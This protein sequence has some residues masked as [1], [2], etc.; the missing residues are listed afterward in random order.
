[1]HYDFDE[2][3][4]RLGTYCTQWDY[5]EDRFNKKDLIPFSISDTDF[6]IPKPITK[7]IH[8][9]ADHQIYGYTRWNHHDFKSSITTYFKRRFDTDMEE[10]RILYSPSVM[11]SVSLLIRLLSQPHDKVLTMNPMYD[12]F[13]NVIK[14]NDR[15]LLSH[16]LI[17]EEGTFKIDFDVFEKQAQES[18]LLLLC[19]PHNPTGRIWSDEEMH[20]M[21]QICKKYQV[22]IISDEIHM[23]IRIKDAKHHPLMKY[24]D[25]YKEI[26]TASSSSKTLNTPGLIGSYVIIPDEKIRDE[27]LGVTRRRDFLNSASIFGMYA[28]MIG[29]TECDDYINQLN[30]YIRGNM[31][32]VENFIRDELKDFKFQRPEATYLAWI[33]ARDVP[34]TS[35]EIQ[36]ALVNVGG[37]AIMK[38]EIYG[39]NGAKYLRMNLGCPRSKIEEGL[40]RFKK[41]MDYLYNK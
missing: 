16:Y 30:E 40:K 32:L 39:E 17:K 38:G 34:F 28:T 14:E 6:I 8:E 27:F 15:E 35:D 10:D 20:R 18:A 23:D 37:V 3:H 24:Y 21:I 41:A 9:V 13:I 22:K 36:D 2:V 4:N 12:A 7:K 25:E 33:D 11:Y 26:F 1:M 5:I 29:Y 19:S 31:E